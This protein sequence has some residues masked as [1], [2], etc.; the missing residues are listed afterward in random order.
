[1]RR[2]S[3]PR[4]AGLTIHSYKEQ[5]VSVYEVVSPLG[6]RA[7]QR[8]GRA[9]RPRTL[10]GVTIGE[11]S[12]NKFDTDFTFREIEQALLKRYPNIRF[13]SHTEF[14][15]T[16]GSRETEVIE[17]LPEKL[18]RLECDVVISGNAG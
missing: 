9:Q 15:D 8:K 5:S 11:L 7:G 1:M 10:D 6:R 14:G 2:E 17:S 12:N 13:V 4:Y 18:A 16:Y 3:R